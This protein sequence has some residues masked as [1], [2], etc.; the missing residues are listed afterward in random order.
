M[1][2]V[3][4]RNAYR[5]HQLTEDILDVTKI[6]SKS[7]KLKKELFDLSDTVSNIINDLKVDSNIRLVYEASQST[8]NN[9]NNLH[10]ICR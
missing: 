9:K 3:I 6:E 10:G 4:I 8:D 2:Q 1:M 7:L 5:L